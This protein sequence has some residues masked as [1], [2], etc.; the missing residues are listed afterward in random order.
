MQKNKIT[1]KTGFSLVE[2][3][4]VIAIIGI[5]SAIAVPSYKSYVI[6]SRVAELLVIAQRLQPLIADKHNNGDTWSAITDL[7]FT[8]IASTYVS[9]VT[10]AQT[11]LGS[12][13]SGTLIGGLVVVGNS[14]AIGVTGNINLVKAGCI[15][16]DEIVWRCGATQPTIDD[17]NN[18]YFPT[19]CQAFL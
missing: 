18:V 12:C 11:G 19:E 1:L 17:G 6:R 14:S 15:N 5:L 13:T 2:L 3:M 7:G 9:S 8:G 16:N 10:A 4:V